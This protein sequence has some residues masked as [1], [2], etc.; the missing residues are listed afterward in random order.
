MRTMRHNLL[1]LAPFVAAVQLASGTA[2]AQVNDPRFRNYFLVGEF[3]EMCTMCEVAFACQA[4]DLPPAMKAVPASGDFTLYMVQ[5][6]TFWSQVST[7]WEWF[8]SNFSSRPLVSGHERPVIE[9]VVT[10]GTWTLPTYHTMRVSLEPA[11][12]TMDSGVEVDRVNRRWQRSGTGEE[13]GFCSRLPLWETLGV[14]EE[15]A[16]HGEQP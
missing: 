11:R 16:P 2:V 3:G 12:L 14:I 9:Y 6:R 4:S 1:L 7:I 10:N 8:I 13:L 15:R 5:T